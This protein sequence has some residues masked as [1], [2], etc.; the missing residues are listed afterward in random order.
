MALWTFFGR[1]QHAGDWVFTLGGYHRKFKVPAHYPPVASMQRL[2]VTFSIGIVRI[3]GGI[4]F[5]ITPKAV[6][7]GAAI[8]CELDIG[9]VYAYLTIPKLL[10]LRIWLT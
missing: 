4:Y 3:S 6:M 7:A 2:G 9:P 1:S 5:A 10:N 8:H